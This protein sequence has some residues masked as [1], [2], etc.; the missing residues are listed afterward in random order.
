MSKTS[1]EVVLIVSYP[2]G[3]EGLHRV[4]KLPIPKYISSIKDEE[5]K[6]E[7]L[8]N[9]AKYLAEWLKGAITTREHQDNQ[10]NNFDCR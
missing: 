9:H 3:D 1:I 2:N 7:E 6:F 8:E 5:L 4:Q 10:L